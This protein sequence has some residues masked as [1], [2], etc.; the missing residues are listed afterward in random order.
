M[1]KII[2][3]SLVA[4]LVAVSS[5]SLE[6]RAPQGQCPPPP[7]GPREPL[8]REE[9][10]K[11][12]AER[13]AKRLKLDEATTQKFIETYC[14]SQDEMWALRPQPRNEK[15]EVIADSAKM[16]KDRPH[17]NKTGKK[18]GKGSGNKAPKITNEQAKEIIA[19][20]F[21]RGQELLDLRKKY[22]NEYSKFLTQR[23]ILK[24][25]DLERSMGEQF[26]QGRNGGPAKAPGQDR[27]PREDRRPGPPSVG[28]DRD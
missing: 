2:Q 25:Y 5:I 17:G 27:G 20:Q 3:F 16:C 24:L 9:L 10:A 1:K 6:A 22:Y 7:G 18:N 11:G 26:A 14:A 4:L 15:G 19:E 23:Q 12:Q 28:P 21:K 8:P 13:I